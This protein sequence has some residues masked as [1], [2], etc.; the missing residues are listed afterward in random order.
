MT[1]MVILE[2]HQGKILPNGSL[3]GPIMWLLPRRLLDTSKA[4][5]KKIFANVGVLR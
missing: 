4:L 1:R 3:W 5:A 2:F